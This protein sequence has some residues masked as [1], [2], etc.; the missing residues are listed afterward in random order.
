MKI[1]PIIYLLIVVLVVFSC[2]EKQEKTATDEAIFSKEDSIDSTEELAFGFNLKDYQ[3]QRDTIKRGDNLS[4][5]LGRYHFDATDIHKITQSISDSFDVK[6]IQ[7]GNVFTILKT[8]TNPSKLQVLIYQPDAMSYNVIDFRDSISAYKVNYPVSYKTKTVAGE[9]D[10]SLYL[11]LKKQGIDAG[12]VRQLSEAF[13]WS[14]DF[15]KFKKGDR[16]GLSVTEK[17]INDSI[18]VGTTQINGA[19]FRYKDKDIYGFPYKINSSSKTEFFDENGKQMRTLFLKAPLK[20]FQITSKFSKKRFHPVQKKWKAHNGTDYAAPHGTP[21]MTTASGVVIQTGYTAGNG[22]FVKVK[23]NN[24]YSTQY[25]HMSRILVKRGQKVTQGQ[26]IG[27]VGSTGLATGPHVCYRFWK[28]GIQVDPLKLH[29]PSNQLMDKKELPSYIKSI[30]PV[31]QAIDLA[32]K[33]K[34]Q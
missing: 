2:K 8:K 26:I 12:L 19:Y 22:N 31:K 30:K 10:G 27:K 11:S 28:N 34:F 4:L 18:Y 21:I 17:Y 24:T 15:F 6:Q 20:Y 14:I 25:L 33:N 13:A 16:F 9:I 29:L 1:H 7:T 3:V 32:L 5:I 23:H